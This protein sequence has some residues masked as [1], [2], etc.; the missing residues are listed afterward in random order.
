MPTDNNL[1]SMNI[2][3]GVPQRVG[4]PVSDIVKVNQELTQRYWQNQ[5]HNQQMTQALKNMPTLVDEIDKPKLAELSN[6]VNTL[7]KKTVDSGNWEDAT[8]TV[9]DASKIISNDEHLKSLQSNY[10]LVAKQKADLEKRYEKE[11]KLRE[12]SNYFLGKTLQQYKESGGSIDKDG[13]AQ[14]IQIFNPTTD[15]DLE[16][17]IK[18]VNEAASKVKALIS[19]QFGN[20]TYMDAT[21]VM[22][23]EDPT[24]RAILSRSML[25]EDKVKTEYLTKDRL[26]QAAMEELQADP[27]FQTKLLEISQAKHWQNTGGRDIVN[28]QDVHDLLVSRG[29]DFE[30]VT[31]VG[32]SDGYLAAVQRLNSKYEHVSPNAANTKAYKKELDAL[33]RNDYFI[34][35]GRNKLLQL[36]SNQLS[37]MYYNIVTGD[38]TKQIIQTVDK[39]AYQHTDIDRHYGSDSK[40]IDVLLAQDKAKKDMGTMGVVDVASGKL[41]VNPNIFNTNSKENQDFKLL[42]SAYNSAKQHGTLDNKTELAYKNALQLRNYQLQLLLTNYD[43]LSASEKESIHNGATSIFDENSILTFSKLNRVAQFLHGFYGQ[44]SDAKNLISNIKPR[45]LLAL[46]NEQ[47]VNKYSTSDMKNRF[48]KFGTKELNSILDDMRQKIGTSIKNHYDKKGYTV[49]V[50]FSQEVTVG[51]LTPQSTLLRQEILH[52]LYAGALTDINT[53]KIINLTDDNYKSVGLPKTGKNTTID[54]NSLSNVEINKLHTHGAVQG[55]I[56]DITIPTM[57]EDPAHK[58]SGKMIP[59]GQVQ[60]LRVRFDG[61][62]VLSQNATLSELNKLSTDFKSN[63]VGFGNAFKTSMDVFNDLGLKRSDIH[64][65]S[66][67]E[68]ITEMKYN[69]AKYVKIPFSKNSSDKIDTYVEVQ[70]N[71]NGKYETKIVIPGKKDVTYNLDTVDD[72]ASV[73]GFQDVKDQGLDPT[74]G[75][76]VHNY[77]SNINNNK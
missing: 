62:N 1:G 28:T 31:S 56:Y 38:M 29:S 47:I 52:S 45:D 40:L 77:L 36:K 42:E 59:N 75:V 60:R 7:F 19:T 27:T 26:E 15:M 44:P 21:T 18:R 41:E 64:N 53:G 30:R 17:D 23:V 76:S 22:Q 33:Q 25:N 16:P 48:S 24:M 20:R 58:G 14:Q 12:Y 34:E 65:K 73:I 9:M 71:R 63:G 43:K 50:P 66:I 37:N 70:L 10:A 54:L 51:T 13:K 5:Q 3:T 68:Y 32:L 35:E 6:T 55:N 57:I 72:I 74:I 67:S 39:Y 61:D 4:A 49:T 69:G 2:I 46:S 8:Q 11:P